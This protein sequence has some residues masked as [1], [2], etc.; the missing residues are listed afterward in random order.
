MNI[1]STMI[2]LSTIISC[3]LLMKENS[4]VYLDEPV[5]EVLTNDS[6]NI[7]MIGDTVHFHCKN[8]AYAQKFYL[9][10][11][12]NNST[13]KEQ[14]TSEFAIENVESSDS[15]LYTCSYSHNAHYSEPSEPVY[16]FVKDKYPPPKITVMPRIIVRPGEDI[17]ITCDAPYSNI[18]FT[19]YKDFKPREHSGE[20]PFSYVIKKAEKKDVGQYACTF[21]TNPGSKTQIE[22]DRSDLMMIQVED[23]HSPSVSWEVYA[24]DDKSIQIICQAPQLQKP[25]KK[26]FQLINSSEGIEEEIMDVEENHVIFTISNPDHI[27]K[28][29]YCIYAIRIGQNIA[30][31]AI[32][33]PIFIWRDDYTTINIIRLHVSALVLLLLGV[34]LMKHFRVSQETEKSP[35]LRRMHAAESKYTEMVI[36]KTEHVSKG[37]LITTA[38]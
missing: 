9:T 16:I 36:M 35:P 33:E 14:I 5:L 37:N 10:K 19:I 27:Q 17:T 34:I 4:A 15:G 1:H 8:L 20:N 32:S 24:G 22:S 2:F 25:K 23:L 26:W 6:N 3:I 12:Q 18:Q 13:R 29:Y 31:S 30:L 21:K 28:K 11:D 38:Q 7:I